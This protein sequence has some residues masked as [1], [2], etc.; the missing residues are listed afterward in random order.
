MA[1]IIFKM[2][3]NYHPSNKPIANILF[4]KLEIELVVSL[5]SRIKV[6]Q[7]APIVFVY[8][9]Y[10]RDYIAYLPSQLLH[11]QSAPVSEPVRRNMGMRR[12]TIQC[13]ENY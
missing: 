4:A 8:C 10:I 7:L 6:S 9:M 3:H 1:K 11:L 5:N 13:L 2:S 12:L